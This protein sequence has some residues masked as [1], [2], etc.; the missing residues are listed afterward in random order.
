M[1]TLIDTILA[2][3]YP[4]MDATAKAKM[5]A[6]LLAEY[7]VNPT[8]FI[9]NLIGMIGKTYM[10]QMEYAEN[11]FD[12]FMG[13]NIPYGTT[14][15]KY[16]LGLP[17]ALTYEVDATDRFDTVKNEP[18]AMYIEKNVKFKVPLSLNP[19]QSAEAFI[20]SILT[21]EFINNEMA[22]VS[23]SVTENLKGLF[24][25]YI[26]DLSHYGSDSIIQCGKTT[27]TGFVVKFIKDFRQIAESNFK[28][29]NT[30][31]MNIPSGVTDPIP[32]RQSAVNPVLLITSDLMVMVKDYF[33][34][35]N[36]NK[37]GVAITLEQLFQDITI[38]IVPDGFATPING[39]TAVTNREISWML[40]QNDTLT[41]NASLVKTVADYPDPSTLT[42]KYYAHWQGYFGSNILRKVAVGV[43]DTSVT[44]P[45]G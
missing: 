12:R 39:T 17:K 33:N 7:E 29:T 8:T 18:V 20:D 14:I 24:A 43:I 5:R 37:T 22:T 11:P 44:V 13:E 31:Y 35:E 9:A 25:T 41:I 16:A 2:E 1:T 10:I 19:D 32:F 26:S 45:A 27:D 36:L 15:Q 6:N 23:R 3:S 34:D 4:E 28:K 42:T 40:L 30:M 21:G 38:V